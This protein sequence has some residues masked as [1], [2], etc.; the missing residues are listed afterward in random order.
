MKSKSNEIKVLNTF[1]EDHIKLV[2][3]YICN[4]FENFSSRKQQASV[5]DCGKNWIETS[6]EIILKSC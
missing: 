5:P 1:L 4:I 3:I 2:Y 6:E